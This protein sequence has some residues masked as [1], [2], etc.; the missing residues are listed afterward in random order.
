MRIISLLFLSLIF[1]LYVSENKTIPHNFSE[2]E[3]EILFEDSISIR[4]LDIY[5]DTLVGF[6]HNKGYGF[7]DLTTKE[8]FLADFEKDIFAK[9]NNWVAEQRAVVFKD[10][11][12]FSLGIGSPAR[13]RKIEI[14]EKKEK[15]VYTETHEKVFYDAIAFWNLEE[16]IAMGDP[17]D[18]CLSIVITRDRG[19][20]WKKVSCK[21]LPPTVAGEAAFAASNGN[22]SIIA[23]KTWVISGGMKSRVF[24]SPDKGK[25]W[26]VFNTPI[27]QGKETTGAYSIDFYDDKTGVIFG[28]DY[29]SPKSNTKNKA[30]TNDGGKTWELV[31]DGT[32]TGYKSCVQYVPNGGGKEI[33]ALGFT[34]ISISNDFGNTWQNIS[35]EGFYTLRFINDSVA[36]AAGKNRVARLI[37][38]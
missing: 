30:I 18:S 37:F 28:G 13:L 36:I 11:S 25:T 34:G 10:N 15:I 31:S 16:G 20:T 17:T 29:T 3:I 7:L 6:G 1:S 33:V 21:D 8:V 22:I 38:K 35:K 4:A 23:D 32:G 12:F 14:K 5:K 24:F 2:V 9:D 26:K 27:I 19:E